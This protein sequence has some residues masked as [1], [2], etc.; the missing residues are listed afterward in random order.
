MTI[1]LIGLYVAAELIANITASK[2]VAVGG[3]VGVVPAAVFIYALTFTLID[4]VNER[5][6]KAGAH[7]VIVAAFAANLLLAGYVKLAV[8][9]PPASFYQGQ[10]AFAQ[11]LGSTPRIVFA[12]LTAYLVAS[13]IDTEVFAWWR[14]RVGRHRWARVLASNA[15]STLVDS[16]VFITLAFSGVMP[17]LPLIRGQYIVKMAV[18]VV[19]I[20]LIYLVRTGLPTREGHRAWEPA[21]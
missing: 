16:A 12:S 13:L 20:P 10:D 19:S 15:V 6:G 14:A 17:L 4:L 7:K 2:P 11:V 5:L 8:S 1:L 3:I 21:P 18:T 9:L